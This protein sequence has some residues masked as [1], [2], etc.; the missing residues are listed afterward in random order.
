MGPEQTINPGGNYSEQLHRDPISGGITLTITLVKGGAFSGAPQTNFA[1]SLLNGIIWYDMSSVFGE[2]FAGSP[3][4][5][6]PSDTSCAVISWQNGT[7]PGGSQVHNCQANTD[8][9]LTLC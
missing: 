1:Y 5:V 9:T 8:L 7:H 3:L 2:P 6:K 4:V